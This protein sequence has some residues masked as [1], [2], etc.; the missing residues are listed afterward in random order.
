MDHEPD[1]MVVADHAGRVIVFNRAASR[2]T[3]L[4]P[5]EVIGRSVFEVLPLRDDD[6]RDWWACTD[7]YHG[8]S[9]RTR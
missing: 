7:P 6:K 2:L 4:N 8:L 3:K 1:G 9:I 5:A